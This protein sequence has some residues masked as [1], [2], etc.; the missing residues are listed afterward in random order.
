M[1]HVAAAIRSQGVGRRITKVVI[2]AQIGAGVKQ[3]YQRYI[4]EP[5]IRGGFFIF[6][7][8]GSYVE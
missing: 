8:F 5:S 6:S 7:I 3:S 2:R 1:V 4:R